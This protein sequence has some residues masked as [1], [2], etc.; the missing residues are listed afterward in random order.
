GET[1]RRSSGRVLQYAGRSGPSSW[2]TRH[3]YTGRPGEHHHSAAAVD[4]PGERSGSPAGHRNPPRTTA[5]AMRLTFS[6]LAFLVILASPAS[7]QVQPIRPAPGGV[8][9]TFQD[10]D[11]GFVLSALAQTA[12]INL[13]YN[14]LPA[15]PITLRTATP[16]PIA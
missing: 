15:K 16:V 10:A 4:R 13:V 11:L 3:R 12:G 1:G 6:A 8:M 5:G 2:R 14:D 9:L 7:A